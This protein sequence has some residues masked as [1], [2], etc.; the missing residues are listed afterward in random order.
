MVYKFANNIW[1]YIK[2]K[3]FP[4]QYARE[5]PNSERFSDCMLRLPLFYELPETSN[6]E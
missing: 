5:F 1:K 3:H 4:D 2:K 6:L